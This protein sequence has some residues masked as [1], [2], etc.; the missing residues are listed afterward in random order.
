MLGQGPY[1]STDPQSP[2]YLKKGPKEAERERRVLLARQQFAVEGLPNPLAF[3]GYVYCFTC[4]L[5]GPAFEY[6]D[7]LK[8]VDDSAF[9]TSP[10]PTGEIKRLWTVGPALQRLLLGVVCMV[11]YLQLAG[12]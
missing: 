6:Q 5:A 1:R 7:Y 8:S 3:F 2:L 11:G 9:K 12:R 4:L 10:G